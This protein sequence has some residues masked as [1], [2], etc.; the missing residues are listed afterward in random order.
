M[1]G[2]VIGMNELMSSRV[3]LGNAHPLVEG[4]D[5]SNIA[6]FQI[7]RTLT[8]CRD[9]SDFMKRIRDL[10]EGLG[11]EDYAF[12]RIDA[13]GEV[14]TR[15]LTSP[16]DMLE[17]YNAEEMYTRDIGVEYIASNVV[18]IFQSEL[19]GHINK[20]PFEAET[21]R[22]NQQI[23]KLL[24]SYG[25][26]DFYFIPCKAHN[27]NGKV[28]LSISSR[29]MD[30]VKF[31]RLVIK[32][33]AFLHE[34]AEVIDYVGTRS[35]PGFFLNE[36]E[37]RDIVITPKPLELLTVLAREDMS[38]NEAAEYLGRSIYT[39]NQQIAVAR[40]ALGAETNH[41]AVYQAIREG[42]IDCKK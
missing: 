34:L 26:Y 41:G 10:V 29:N 25:F 6:N 12:A 39:V 42:L 40:K 9:I 3:I 18:P 2:D 15:I 36:H 13:P 27:G 22:A 32:N 30:P 28:V 17:L 38:L 16:K 7:Y 5:N 8:A 37:S 20:L 35:F 33:Q 23:S 21:I 4:D 19:Y 1:S 14:E 11:F 24:K 31:Q